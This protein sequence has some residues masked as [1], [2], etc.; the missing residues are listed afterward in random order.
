MII[1]FEF[2]DNLAVMVLSIFLN[3]MLRLNGFYDI[4][5]SKL[6]LIVY[7]TPIINDLL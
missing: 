6:F 1:L 4:E 2:R 5:K 7:I 3:N